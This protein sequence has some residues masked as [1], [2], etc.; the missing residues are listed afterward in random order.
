MMLGLEGLE[1]FND[2]YTPSDLD[3]LYYL[4]FEK[5]I[6]YNE[7]IKLP[8]PYIFSIMRTHGYIHKETKTKK[9]G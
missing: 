4:F 5:G 2:D 1:E 6:S 3:R 7:F 9:N 8:M